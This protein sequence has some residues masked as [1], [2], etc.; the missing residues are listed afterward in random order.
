MQSKRCRPILGKSAY[1]AI[2][3]VVEIK[4]SDAIQQPDASGG[5]V[6]SVPISY[7][8]W[9]REPLTKQQV[10]GMF[11]DV[12]DEGL[13]LLEVEYHNRPSDST[14]PIQRAPWQG[15]VALRAKGMARRSLNQSRNP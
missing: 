2:I 7:P 9:V 11:P 3:V 14:K 8:L 10:V 1:E 5:Q 6:S 13:G 15:Q 4:D 12:F